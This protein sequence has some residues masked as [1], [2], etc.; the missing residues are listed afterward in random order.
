MIKRILLVSNVPQ[1]YIIPLFNELDRQ[2]REKNMELKIVFASGGYKRRKFMLDFSE[3]TFRYEILKSLKLHFGNNEKTFFTYSGINRVISQYKPDKIIVA[4]FSPATVKIWLRSFFQSMNYVIWSG[5]WDFPGRLDSWI[6]KSQRRALIRRASAFVASGSKAK[7]YL[8]NMGAPAEKIFIAINT[9]DTKFFASE[10][11]KIRN[12][13]KTPGKKHLICFGYLVPRK[14]VS[15]LIEVIDELAKT[16]NDFIFDI[17][18]DGDERAKLEKI[19]AEKKLDAVIKFHGFIQKNDLPKYL[20]AS[21]CFLFQTDFDV[22]G[23]VVN[24]AMAAGVPVLSSVNAG[25]TYDL[26]VNGENGFA[27]DYNDKN[28]VVQKI[29]SLLDNSLLMESMRKNA[30][31]FIEKNA[32]IPISAEGL[33]NSVLYEEKKFNA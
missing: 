14:N 15:K 26:I 24:E 13:D 19:V 3:I 12:A 30:E 9:V 5:A 6:R 2:C 20:A 1:P 17:L 4:G 18:G 33:L 21:S 25:A 31:D 28:D 11:K 7:E 8:V 22:W 32:T 23:L 27:V 16:R 29:N 10:T